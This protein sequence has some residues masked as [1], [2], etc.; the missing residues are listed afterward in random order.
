MSNIIDKMFFATRATMVS[1]FDD[2]IKKKNK[3]KLIS[4][5]R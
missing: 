5:A 1:P 2:I 4:N 3:K